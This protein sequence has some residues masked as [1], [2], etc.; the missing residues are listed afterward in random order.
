MFE[1]FVRFFKGLDGRIKV[2][3]S[4]AAVQYWSQAF[5]G[6]YNQLYAS[7]LGADYVQIGSLNSIGAGITSIVSVPLGWA[8][9][10]Y[11]VRRTLLLG[12]ACAIISAA[13]YA[14]AGSWWILVAAVILSSI[15]LRIIYPLTDVIFITYT[16]PEQSSTLMGFSRV[17]WGTLNIFAP[18]I[19][20]IIV[21]SF[22]GI[23]AQG[24][25]PLYFV[26]LFLTVV[27]FFFVAVKLKT[28][29]THVKRE[30]EKPSSKEN[31]FIQ[32]FRDLFKGE[33]WL[34]RWIALRTIDQFAV[35]MAVPFIPLWMVN[36][37]GANPYILGAV[38]TASA[39]TSSLLQVPAGRL[40][41]KIGRKRT[42]YLLQ[43][44]AYIGTFMLILAPRP[45]YLILV[46]LL[47]AVGLVGGGAG[48]VSSTPFITMH[49]EMVPG[50]KRGRWFGIEG[51]MTGSTIPATII[52]GIL[53]QYGF[54]R[55]V[56]LLPILLEVLVVIP[57][58]ITVPDTLKR[59]DR[60]R[61]SPSA[62][63]R[64]QEI[65]VSVG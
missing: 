32:D 2:A 65:D 43:P 16:R 34:K 55:E 58:M 33:R 27:A 21:A 15:A 18:L 54:M 60:Q 36:V 31:G 26:Q 25:R 24:I 20:A 3:M 56:L 12:F 40:A 39:V 38:G 17:I 14:L 1:G 53:W 6:Q 63:S 8:A 30:E 50:E 59:N 41:D 28:I 22:G 61:N 4:G 10:N 64:L 5:S 13:V 51:L 7:V 29:P 46:G 42:Y 57:L 19:A 35:N 45:E 9:E 37:K 44:L 49:W 48:G 52:G 47:G 11:G 23:N 62:F